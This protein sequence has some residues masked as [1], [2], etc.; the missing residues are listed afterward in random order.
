MA[1]CVATCPKCEKRF[2]LVWGIGKKKLLLST[3]IRPSCPACASSFEQ[4][5][6]ELVVVDRSDDAQNFLL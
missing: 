5:E 6:I 2:R 1:F 4:T 3:L